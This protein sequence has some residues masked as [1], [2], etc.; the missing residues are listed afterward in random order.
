[1]RELAI[2]LGVLIAGLATSALA[3][4][5][6]LIPM[7]AIDDMAPIVDIRV[8]A[9]DVPIP[10]NGSIL[11]FAR[12]DGWDEASSVP[13][14]Q[15]SRV[16]GATT[17]TFSGTMVNVAPYY[18]AWTPLEPLEAGE[19]VVSLAHQGFGTMSAT[20][21]VVGDM[22]IEPPAVSIT[23]RAVWEGGVVEF[24]I[25]EYFDGID[26]VPGPSI[27]TRVKG[28]ASLN[29][30]LTFTVEPAV[31]HQFLYRALPV[32]LETGE[33]VASAGPLPVGPFTVQAEQYCFGIEAM[34]IKTGTVHAYPGV[35]YC[36]P[37]GDIP[38]FIEQAAQITDDALSR[39]SCI[40]PPEGLEEQWCAANVQCIEI[41]RT[42]DA[43]VANS[44]Q[45]YFDTCPDAVRPD[46]GVTGT[47]MDAGIPD[48]GGGRADA[49]HPL[50]PASDDAA[51]NGDAS[52]QDDVARHGSG[53]AVVTRTKATSA[54]PV[55]GVALA[56]LA[57]LGAR[58]RKRF[59]RLVA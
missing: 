12:A 39:Y 37:H 42:P 36:A 25:C 49:G 59:V 47:I 45:F 29:A 16:V 3:Q 2:G 58:A 54:S 31:S 11:L 55:A 8:V 33:Y 56:L 15:V 6:P 51:V 21:T 17:T 28:Q 30:P 43:V 27:A 40:R 13:I 7:V 35:E 48:A 20:I 4:S 57:L 10:R 38:D 19:Y 26:V 18:F 44:C 53:C 32:G 52:D 24:G 14:T 50:P 5:D 41:S 46:A 1:M 9:P 34:D 22:V 23:P